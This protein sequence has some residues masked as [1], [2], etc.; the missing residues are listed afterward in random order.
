MKKPTTKKQARAV[1]IRFDLTL[2]FDHLFHDIP[3]A[4]DASVIRRLRTVLVN[5]LARENIG[6][7]ELLPGG[8]TEMSVDFRYQTLPPPGEATDGPDAPPV[9]RMRRTPV[10]S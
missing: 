5:E 10:K 9:S 8:D 1:R 3:A 7:I 2:G 4:L 6:V